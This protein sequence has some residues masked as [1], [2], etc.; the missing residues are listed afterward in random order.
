MLII[1]AID[2]MDGRVVR[3]C[4]GKSGKKVYSDSPLDV[5]Q[6]WED[7]GAKLIHVVDLDGAI[8]GKIK[9]LKILKDILG[10][11]KV[12]VQFGGGVRDL[13]TI[14]KILDYGVSRV[15]LGTRAVEDKKFLKSAFLKFGKK[16]IVS[17]DAKSGALRTRGW[18]SSAK[19]QNLNDFA[20]YLKELGFSELVFTNIA[21]DGMLGGPDLKG[22]KSILGKAKIKIIA[23]GG[24]SSL[25]DII[26]LKELTKDGLVGIVIGKALYEERFSLF[27][28]IKCGS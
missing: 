5:A 24:I 26:K 12:P 16:I 3:L 18:Q 1:P 6:K 8:K 13:K 21:C 20:C 2:I 17:V 28:A 14:K 27:D 22:I 19:G 15:V 10:S 7:Q 23:S 4:Q 9:N 11:I 25:E